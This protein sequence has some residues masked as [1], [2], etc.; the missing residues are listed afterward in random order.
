MGILYQHGEIVLITG[1]MYSSKTTTLISK[2]ER[3]Q[4]ANKKVLLIKYSHDLRYTDGEESILKSHSLRSFIPD[5]CIYVEKLNDV[6][7]DIVKQFD[8]IGIDEGQFFPDII[9]CV[10]WAN[11]N[12]HVFISALNGTFHQT[13][14]EN[15]HQIYPWADNI[16][17]LTAVCMNCQSYDAPF[18]KKTINSDN[19]NNDIDIGGKDK[20]I[21]VCRKCLNL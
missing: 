5:K 20:Y 4:I 2:L 17:H 3:F 7:N 8:V 16:I 10:K 18:T 13:G 9:E 6:S 19:D 1:P 21:A 15:F 12:K 11:E 14:F